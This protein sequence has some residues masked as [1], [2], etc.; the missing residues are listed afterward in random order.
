MDQGSIRMAVHRKRSPPPPPP[1]TTG[2]IAGRNEI[3]NREKSDG[4]IFGTQ[5]FGS[6]APAPTFPSNTPPGAGGWSHM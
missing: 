5:T 1:Q 2:T 4:A 6:Q 3:Y